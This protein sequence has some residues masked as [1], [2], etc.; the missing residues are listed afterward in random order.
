MSVVVA[1]VVQAARLQGPVVAAAAIRLSRE[2][3][4]HFLLRPVVLV[5]AVVGEPTAHTPVVLVVAVVV[6]RVKMVQ[7]V[8]PLP[9]VVMVVVRTDRQ[10][11]QVTHPV[12]IPVQPAHHYKVEPERMAVAHKA[13]MEAPIMV[14]RMAVAMAEQAISLIIMPVVVVVVVDMLVVVVDR[15]IQVAAMVLVVVVVDRAT[16]QGAVVALITVQ[17]QHQAT[18][19]TATELGRVMQEPQVAQDQALPGR[20]APEVSF[21][22]AM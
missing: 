10:E 5:V 13:P 18:I 20:T 2:A 4:P 19:L 9:V 1:V 8:A 6:H 7:L 11:E 12:E 22:L 3:V 16:R 14:A 17:V 21:S 15:I